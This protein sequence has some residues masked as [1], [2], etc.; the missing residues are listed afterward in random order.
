MSLPLRITDVHV[1]EVGDVVMGEGLVTP[2]ARK[3]HTH[4]S[5]LVVRVDTD[6][7]LSGFAMDG[8]WKGEMP[9][10][11]ETIRSLVAPALIG[12]S[13]F[14]MR[15][16]CRL[17][18]SVDAPGR[19]NFIEIALWDIVGRALGEPLFR[20]WGGRSDGVLAYAST[21]HYGK[22]VAE[23][24]RDCL[25]YRDRGYR[26]IKLRFA[27]DTVE[28]DLAYAA[29]IRTAVGDDVELMV[30]AN[31]TS[32]RTPGPRVWSYQRALA[33]AKGLHDLDATWLEAPLS[34]LVPESEHV[35]LTRESPLAIAGGEGSKGFGAFQK[36]A[37]DR[38]YDIVQPDPVVSGTAS[39]LLEIGDLAE[40]A[41]L[42]I[43]CH[44]GKSGVGMLVALHFQAAIGADR[45]LETMD[46]PGHWNPD[47]FQAGFVQPLLPEPGGDGIIR[48]PTAPGLG[49][50][51]DEEWL[52]RI[53]LG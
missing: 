13:V 30:D 47:G 22:T 16:H 4:R 44:H 48:C 24:V 50:P 6:E 43:A 39:T 10:D 7:G 8:D 29:A 38:L 21:V 46:D 25:D 9:T 45:Y 23:R 5:Y 34:F 3:R 28:D 14:D 26:A 12:R 42:R 1:A 18:E 15:R 31:Q 53:G 17:L 40:A 11:A 35:R 33:T 19:F 32:Q 36:M 41:G 49:A 2:W 20:L 52:D 27:E 37:A 51:W